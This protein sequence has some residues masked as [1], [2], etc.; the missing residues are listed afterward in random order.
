M[1]TSHIHVYVLAMMSIIF[2][3]NDVSM[4]LLWIVNRVANRFVDHG[5]NG[6]HGLNVQKHV[7]GWFAEHAQFGVSVFTVVR[8]Q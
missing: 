5:H 8:C 3:L 6:Y 1:F 4:I 7:V 2:E